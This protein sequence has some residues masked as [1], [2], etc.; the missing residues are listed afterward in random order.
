M[1]LFDIQTGCGGATTGR[2]DIV[3]A[4]ELV[5][6]ARRLNITRSLVRILP[7]DMDTDVVA[8]NEKLLAACAAH[9][10]LIPCPVLVPN[11][12]YD[13]APEEQQV[14][15][16]IRKG[17]GA[18]CLRPERDGWSVAPWSCDK[19]FDALQARRLPAFCKLGFFT[20]EQAADLAA[21]YPAL[22]IILSDLQYAQ[23]RL[24]LPLLGTFRNVRMSTGNN[25]EVFMGLEQLVDKLGPEQI[26]FGTGFPVS[27]P[28]GAVTYLAYADIPDDHRR[29]IASGNMEKLVENIVR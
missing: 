18:A 6:D 29:L 24:L 4:D 14:D 1:T 7:E 22:P 5:A 13:L 3:S 25:Y 2:K 9:D 20:L 10:G 23:Q 28:A 17:A 16:A 27:E 15:E 8:S 21:R 19:L 26:L 11:T 12:G